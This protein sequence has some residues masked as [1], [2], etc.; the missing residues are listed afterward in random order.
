M[1]RLEALE[2]LLAASVEML[3]DIDDKE[4]NMCGRRVTVKDDSYATSNV[5]YRCRDSCRDFR[6]AVHAAERTKET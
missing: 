1:T 5:F 3:R 6:F 4:R 2:K